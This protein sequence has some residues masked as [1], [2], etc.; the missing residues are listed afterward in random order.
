MNCKDARAHTHTHTHTPWIEADAISMLQSKP[1]G[2]GDPAVMQDLFTE[3]MS[4]PDDEKGRG[5]K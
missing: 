5:R 3:V 2:D 1:D 4:I